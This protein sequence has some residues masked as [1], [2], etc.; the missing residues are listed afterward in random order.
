MNTREIAFHILYD[1][2]EKEE[3][4]HLALQ[5][6]W[7]KYPELTGQDRRFIICLV[8]GTLEKQILLDFRINQ[9]SKVSV[10]RMKP[11]IRVLMR[12]SAYQLFYMDRV[13]ASAVCN[14]AVKLTGK[15]HMQGLKGFVNGVL[16]AMAREENWPEESIPVSCSVPDWIAE[17]WYRDFGTEKAET[18]MKAIGEKSVLSFRVHKN[19][20]DEKTILDSLRN[21]QVRI[22]KAPFP[23]DGWIM[24]HVD[25]LEELDAMKNGWIQIQDISSMMV[26][27]I[28]EPGDGWNVLDV[29]A[30]PGGKSI[31]L[32]EELNGSGHVIS[33]DLTPQKAAKIEENRRRARLDNLDVKVADAREFHPEWEKKMDLVVADLPCSGL[34]VLGRKP[35]IRYRLS[36]G[37]ILELAALQKE[38]LANV[39]RYVRPGGYMIFSTCTV[40]QEENQDN[41]QWILENLPFRAVSLD[42]LLPES[43]KGSTTAEGHLQLLPGVH[44]CDGFY[45]SKFQRKEE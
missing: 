30:A 27:T 44:P 2:E 36:E 37:Q 31:H 29:C 38:I 10:S 26:G 32:A 33:C 9:K 41:Y 24:E 23:D 4:S 5:N 12:M 34:G 21:Q 6:A 18:M 45:I 15:L 43:L 35:E 3:K 1:V 7:E 22:R 13:P 14:E 8:Q 20:A 42:A 39:S 28:A 11:A 17:R 19:L 25:K 40:T 16:R